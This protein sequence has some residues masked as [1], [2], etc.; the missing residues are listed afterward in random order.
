M[1]PWFLPRVNFFLGTIQL[2]RCSCFWDEENK[3]VCY[4]HL[5]LAVHLITGNLRSLSVPFRPGC[6]P[7]QKQCGECLRL[8]ARCISGSRLHPLWPP[9]IQSLFR[10][11][12][13][14]PCSPLRFQ[15][16]PFCSRMCSAVFQTGEW[17][18][19][20]ILQQYRCAQ[21]FAFPWFWVK[22]KAAILRISTDGASSVTL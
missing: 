8:C 13:K 12:G 2:T 10:L 20:T 7:P 9:A 15:P 22:L 19:L 18:L 11:G 1:N 21:L 17:T 14:K 5:V 4:R 3:Q 6:R 16:F